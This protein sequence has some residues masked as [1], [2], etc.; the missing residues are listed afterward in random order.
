MLKRLITMLELG[1]DVH[2]SNSKEDILVVKVLKG[3]KPIPGSRDVWEEEFRI[4]NLTSAKRGIIKKLTKSR[5]L[6]ETE[7]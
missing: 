3:E 6:E 5:S 7:E 1:S 4:K 2:G